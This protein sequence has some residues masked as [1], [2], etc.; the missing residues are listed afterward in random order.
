MKAGLE[1]HGNILELLMTH[2]MLPLNVIEDGKAVFLK[3]LLGGADYVAEKAF[4]DEY[5]EA[6]FAD[7]EAQQ[8][9]MQPGSLVTGETA[10][11]QLLR[12][13]RVTITRDG[14][15][16]VPVH[17]VM[18][19]R[20]SSFGM[21]QRGVSTDRLA[22]GFEAL[23]DD[24]R[25]RRVMLDVDSPGGSVFG[26]ELATEALE[27][28]AQN[29]PV[30]SVAN[31]VMA[32][33]SFYLA[34]PSQRIDVTPGSAVGSVG[35]Y[36]VRR[37]RSVAEDESGDKFHILSAGRGK[38]FGHPSLPLTDEEVR[39]TMREINAYYDQFTE[40]V[41]AGRGL[42]QK[43]IQD[44]LGA[45]VFIGE[46]AVDV[47]FA[48]GVSSLE[49]AVAQF[50]R[51]D[52]PVFP[53]TSNTPQAMKNPLKLVFKGAGK[54]GADVEAVAVVED[55]SGTETETEAAK[56]LAALKQE[57]AALAKEKEALET[58]RKQVA[59]A[60]V[61]AWVSGVL[62]SGKLLPKDRPA[63]EAML[64]KLAEANVTVDVT[65]MGENDKP[66]VKTL[67]AVE[68]VQGFVAGQPV[69]VHYDE[70][71]KTADTYEEKPRSENGKDVIANAAQLNAIKERFK[72]QDVAEALAWAQ[73]HEMP[74]DIQALATKEAA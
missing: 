17:G 13:M 70:K 43:K 58:E 20:M 69:Q 39:D 23:A 37:D 60:G 28:L 36:T 66:E 32:S 34:M 67:T 7:D 63:I 33:G 65:V 10:T 61:D 68:I 4:W 64:H 74:D 73:R 3:R 62:A 5:L 18:A 46:Q 29:K 25:A 38:A 15:A 40:R 31:A 51:E 55:D 71:A 6:K 11:D 1:N 14:T 24:D 49:R 8:V 16:I 26:V 59:K 47:G 12:R 44:E 57:R 56:E 42:T 50:E 9:L 21:S 19:K 2:W 54:D 52:R 48:D 45:S 35:V 30:R 53:I 27:N 72:L 22:R 41:E